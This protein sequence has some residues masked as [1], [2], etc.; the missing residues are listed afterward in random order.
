MAGRHDG[1]GWSALMAATAG[2]RV[3]VALASALLALEGCA[4][5]NPEW[6]EGL[7]PCCG[8]DEVL[9]GEAPSEPGCADLVVSREAA[10]A[11]AWMAASGS[12]MTQWRVRLLPGGPACIWKK[13]PGL[14]EEDYLDAQDLGEASA[15]DT[16]RA[17]LPDTTGAPEPAAE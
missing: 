5:R 2:A 4:S 16:L 13:W 11:V 15:G 9:A 10:L 14:T 12:G 7:N 6:A 3:G 17:A 1:A 8:Q